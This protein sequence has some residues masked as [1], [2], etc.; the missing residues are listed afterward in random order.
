MATALHH[1][2]EAE[3]RALGARA[4]SAAQALAIAGRAVKDRA[5]MAAPASLLARAGEILQA[6]AK[7]LAAARAR[8]L[9]A[10]LLDRLALDPKRVEAMAIGLELG[11]ALPD[12]VG[13][14]I[15]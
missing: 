5:L 7:D 15:D 9:R 10:S 11:A 13:A 14:P 12:P 6:N 4:R 1:D 2:L 8:G 3:M